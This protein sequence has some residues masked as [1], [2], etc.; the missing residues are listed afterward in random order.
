M[1]SS[2]ILVFVSTSLSVLIISIFIAYI[3]LP[4]EQTEGPT[5]YIHGSANVEH[6]QDIA[7]L[8][9]STTSFG[10]YCSSEAEHLIEANPGDIVISAR[11]DS[12]DCRYTHPELLSYPIVGGGNYD[13]DFG[14]INDP[15]SIFISNGLAYGEILDFYI[16]E[17]NLGDAMAE[18]A[19][20]I[21]EVN[22]VVDSP[23]D[24]RALV[25][26]LKDSG[27]G[28]YTSPDGKYYGYII[29]LP[30]ALEWAVSPPD[31]PTPEP[32]EVGFLPAI[33]YV[34]EN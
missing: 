1:K 19:N 2:S 34:L 6:D 30:R 23:M 9:N 21:L 27:D 29:N 15:D 33:Y 24:I 17:G 25:A 8:V 20:I 32:K 18:M 11:A 4:K 7:S 5:T 31:V 14:D 10:L 12:Y 28:I 13:E 22:S 3:I 26:L 16:A